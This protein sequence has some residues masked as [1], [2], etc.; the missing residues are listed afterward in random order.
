ML[1][2]KNTF[3]ITFLVLFI[4]YIIFPIL[5]FE[6]FMYF[7]MGCFGLAVLII[8]CNIFIVIPISFEIAIKLDS[9]WLIFFVQYIILLFYITVIFVIASFS[10]KF[11]GTNYG[12]GVFIPISFLIAT[13]CRPNIEEDL[14]KL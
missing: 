14:F 11:F 4:S 2:I 10:L 1:N 7:L 12:L 3:I 13:F 6:N 9:D 8:L 5:Y